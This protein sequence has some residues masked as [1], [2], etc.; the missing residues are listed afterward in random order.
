[1]HKRLVA[2]PWSSHPSHSAQFPGH[3]A[4]HHIHPPLSLLDRAQCL[5][6]YAISR[7]DITYRDDHT[8]RRLLLLLSTASLLD[9]ATISSD[10]SNFW[11]LQDNEKV[12]RR[13]TKSN[14]FKTVQ[15]G[16]CWMDQMYAVT[17]TL[18]E[19][20]VET[21]NTTKS[22]RLRMRQFLLIKKICHLKWELT[23]SII[24]AVCMWWGLRMQSRMM[25]G[26]WLFTTGN[27][28]PWLKKALQ[29]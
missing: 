7:Q 22:I 5:L 9:K 19:A 4:L 17:I 20:W 21:H 2:L 18:Q 16:R 3:T 14:R 13:C 10:R 11:H 25:T 24:M 1:M 26:S 12:G 6:T 8:Y 28:G 29:A 23:L 15:R 27:E